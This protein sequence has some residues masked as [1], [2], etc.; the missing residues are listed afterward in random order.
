MVNCEL[1]MSSKGR[2]SQVKWF[3]LSMTPA[4][5][6]STQFSMNNVNHAFIFILKSEKLSSRKSS[7]QMLSL[8]NNTWNICLFH[9]SYVT[10]M[11][12]Y[13]VEL[14]KCR[15]WCSLKWSSIKKFVFKD[16]WLY[17]QLKQAVGVFSLSLILAVPCCCIST[18]SHNKIFL[19]SWT[20]TAYPLRT[21]TGL[22]P[23]LRA[24]AYWATHEF[25]WKQDTC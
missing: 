5:R 24:T 13:T 23:T 16:S 6:N 18:L 11:S 19:F 3:D 10:I 2:Y 1:V 4:G 21:R 9:L 15:W 7:S 17:L 14:N 22:H 8:S 20:A 12:F 25:I